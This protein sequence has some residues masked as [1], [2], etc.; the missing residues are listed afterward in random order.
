MSQ[1]ADA[2]PFKAEKRPIQVMLVDDSAVVRGMIR[3][4]LDPKTD[5]EVVATSSNGEIAVATLKRNPDIDL[6]VLD[7]IHNMRAAFLNFVNYL[8]S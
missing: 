4:Y 6:I 1:T 3:R 7:H 8:H 2:Q 5:I